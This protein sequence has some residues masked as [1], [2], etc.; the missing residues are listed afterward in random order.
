VK[1]R[2]SLPIA[3]LAT[4]PKLA[5]DATRGFDGVDPGATFQFPAP[6]GTASIDQYLTSGWDQQD[7]ID[8][9][10]AY[11]KVFGNTQQFPYL[12]IPGTFEYWQ[13]LDVHLS[14]AM[15]GAKS[16][17]DALKATADDWEATTERLGRDAQLKSYKASLGL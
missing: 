11:F 4:T 3:L 2:L 1:L 16:P 15:T 9:T 10:D 14:E 13:S 6:N 5:M 8:Y 12:R 17:E 7:A